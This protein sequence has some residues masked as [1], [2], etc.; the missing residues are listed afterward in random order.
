MSRGAPYR[1]A[2]AHGAAAGTGPSRESKPVPHPKPRAAPKALCVHGTLTASRERGVRARRADDARGEAA[3][4]GA[5]GQAEGGSC[6][7]LLTRARAGGEGQRALAVEKKKKMVIIESL[8]TLQNALTRLRWGV[9][10]V[11]EQER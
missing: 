6:W 9:G 4:G 2:V 10:T 11:W 5:H 1:R 7:P 8:K 3:R